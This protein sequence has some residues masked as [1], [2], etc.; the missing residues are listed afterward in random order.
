MKQ[1]F[2]VLDVGVSAVNIEE[3]CQE[4]DA[5]IRENRREYVCVAP[6]A[7][8][9]D[10]RRDPEY[11]KI[12]N[13]A[14]M[15]TPDGMPVVWLGRLLGHKNVRRTYGPDLML[16]VCEQGH[17]KGFRHYF[18]GSLPETCDRLEERL[19]QDF[20]WIKIAGKYSPPFRELSREEDRQIVEIINHLQPDIIWVG[21]GSPKQDFW[22]A[23]HRE[24]LNVPVMIG[25]GA[26]FDFLS[27][28]KKQAPAWM[29]RL[30]LEW[31]FRLCCE[32]KRL[33]RRY[34]VGNTLFIFWLLKEA[35]MG[36]N[37][38]HKP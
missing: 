5:I 3:A 29:Q 20:P 19:R 36:K 17:L 18:Y 7:T 25:V 35:L 23:R 24:H 2:Y 10:C 14:C 8:I 15:T 13:R 30:G 11:K 31:F 33:W 16:A 28:V 4:I 26:A 9:V 1:K 37:A 32:P 21:L 34:L 27:G 6:V 12:I 22:M 38:T